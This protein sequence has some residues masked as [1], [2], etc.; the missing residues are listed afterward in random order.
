MSEFVFN[1][2]PIIKVIWRRG[3]GLESHLTDWKSRGANSRSV[4]SRQE[5]YPLHQ[6]IEGIFLGFNRGRISASSQFRNEQKLPKI[7]FIIPSNS[8]HVVLYFGKMS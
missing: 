2:P 6:F 4:G 5:F 3:H 1:V 8:L 7:V